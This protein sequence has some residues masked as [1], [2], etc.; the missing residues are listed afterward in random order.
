MDSGNKLIFSEEIKK[1]DN[2]SEGSD[3]IIY[4]T[5]SFFPFQFFPDKLII[6]V[7]KITLVR[8]AMLFNRT[9]PILIEDILTVRITNDF[10][11]SSIYFEVRAFEQNPPPITFIKAKE[12]ILAE[13]Y[14]LALI[15]SKNDNIDLSK[16]PLKIL[17]SKL[18]EI[19]VVTDHGKSAI[20]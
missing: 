19:G 11:F 14:V 10:F 4:E 5:S 1:L 9:T 20:I 2:L 8:N 17:K 13:T 15:K 3:K 12:A 7:N 6:D 18:K 16:I